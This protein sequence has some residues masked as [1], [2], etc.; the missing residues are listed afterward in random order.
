VVHHRRR[1]LSPAASAF[2]HFLAAHPIRPE[3]P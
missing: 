1:P 3:Q 2:L